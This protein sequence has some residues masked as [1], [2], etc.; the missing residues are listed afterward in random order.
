MSKNDWKLIIGGGGGGG[1]RGWN[2]DDLDG[3]KSKN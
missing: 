1:G 2:K 3:K